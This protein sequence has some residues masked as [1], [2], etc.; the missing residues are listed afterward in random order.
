MRKTLVLAGLM[1]ALLTLTALM[2]AVKAVTY[3]SWDGIHFVREGH[4]K[5]PHPDRDYYGISPYSSWSARGYQLYHYQIN[6]AE[7]LALK[8]TA[9]ALGAAIGVVVG[10]LIPQPW[11]AI[12]GGATG[13]ALATYIT[14]VFEVYLFDEVDCIWW[15]LSALFVDWLT[16][17][18]YWLGPLCARDPA[19]GYV[20][21]LIAFVSCGYLRVGMITFHD[22]LEII[23][24]TIYS[25]IISAGE[26]GTTSPSPANRRYP[27][28]T[29]VNVTA[30]PYS[31]WNFDCWV[32]D[33]VTKMY[34]PITIL[35]DSDHTLTA[36]FKRPSGGGWGDYIAPG[37][38]GDGSVEE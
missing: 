18:A 3:Y 38:P 11:G 14:Y 33:G 9:T 2:P 28:G 15:W 5:Y 27:S 4:I 17:N 23:G 20:Q 13:I 24:P 29:S 16:A 22:A 31:G 36:Y 25:L 6:Q 35:M 1:L 30:C 26:G 37:D 8:L 7:S 19:A 10:V 12:I 21:I 32:K 34:S